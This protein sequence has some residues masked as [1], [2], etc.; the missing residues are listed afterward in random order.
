MH[1]SSRLAL[2]VACLTIASAGS[3]LPAH[4]ADEGATRACQ[5]QLIAFAATVDGHSQLFT[6]ASN[7]AGLRQI[8]HDQLEYRNP[9][10]SP[11]GRRL[12]FEVDDGVSTSWL[13]T[14][15]PD[16]SKVTRLPTLG[17][18]VGQPSFSPDGRQ[19]Y[20]TR[21]DGA[22]EEAVYR[23]DLAGN[24]LRRVTAPPAGHGDIDPNVSPDG[25]TVSFVRL[26][27]GTDDGPAALFVQDLATGR[28]RQLTS[29]AA[30]VAIKQDWSPD[31]RRIGFTRDGYDRPPGA[32]SNVVAISRSGRD[33]DEVT[34]F[35][36][37]VTQ[38]FF[39]SYSPEGRW[40]VI[41][42]EDGDDHSLVKIRP[43]GTHPKTILSVPGFTP[44]Y[45]AW[46][47]ACAGQ[48]R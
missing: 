11:D 9:E 17:A 39:G 4:A 8:T 31:G 30:N 23:V 44:R 16:G 32:N 7:G 48:V 15:R 34:D 36:D 14:A 13:A 27:D 10:W 19:I 40:I 21:Y 6:V 35:T 5:D 3:A 25:K 28:E 29:Y 46:G 41:R 33:Q 24:H 37:G 42:R 18:Q 47:P 2:L 43:N 45:I 20:F 12:V 1:R 22:S 38:A 26:S